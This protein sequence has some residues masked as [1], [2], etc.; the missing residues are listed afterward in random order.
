MQRTE[1]GT[2]YS[3][4]GS[5]ALAHLRILAQASLILNEAS[6]DLNC[7]FSTVARLLAEVLG[8][9][10]VVFFFADDRQSLYAG[11][12]EHRDAGGREVFG[13]QFGNGEA[14]P[15]DGS[16]TGLAVRSR[17]VVRRNFASAGQALSETHSVLHPYVEA[18]GM[19]GCLIAPL[20]SRGD[21]I[22]VIS[23]VRDQGGKPYSDEDEILLAELASRAA[24]TIENAR[25]F[26]R[27]QKSE[28]EAAAMAC[29]LRLITD[30]VPAQISY[31]DSGLIYRSVN[32]AYE[33]VWS[34]PR[35]QIIGMS[36]E[37]LIGPE[38]F[39]HV[40][41]YLNRVRAGEAVK[42]ETRFGGENARYREISF[43]PDKGDGTVRGFFALIVDI[44]ERKHL[45]LALKKGEERFRQ[46]TEAIPQIVYTADKHG[47]TEYIN[48]QWFDYTGINP[49]NYTPEIGNHSLHPDDLM[50][51]R[52][53]W[54]DA[55]RKGEPWEARARLRRHDGMYRW[56]L[57]RV[58][59]FKD[60]QGMLTGWFGTSTDIHDQKMAQAELQRL[61]D[62]QERSL[63]HMDSFLKSSP[64]AMCLINRELRYVHA[65][66]ALAVFNGM[67][68]EEMIGRTLE[69]VIPALAPVL[70]PML[71][72]VLQTGE[73]VLNFEVEYPDPLPVGRPKTCIV[74][75]YPARSPKLEGGAVIGVGAVIVDITEHKA[76]QRRLEEA[77]R[78]RD[79]FLSI[80]SH[81]LKTPLTALQL[82]IE[83]RQLALEKRL[84]EACS[85]AHIARY[86][87]VDNRQV[88]RLTRLVEDMLDVARID[89][90]KF[91]IQRE[92]FDLREMVREVTDRFS[93]SAESQGV[94][95]H[96]EL[97]E[98]LEGEWDHFR[99]EQVY[100][101]L[102]TNA[103]RYG[104]GK[105]VQVRVFRNGEHAVLSV[106]DEGIGIAPENHERVFQRFERA[107]SANEVGG[108]GLGLYISR[109]IVES[110][111]GRIRVESELGCGAAFVVTLPL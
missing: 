77:I 38:T 69:E 47:R 9:A 16:L 5:E 46:I 92:R 66:Q 111:G 3:R 21:V 4:P 79:E 34:L 68:L 32:A 78:A 101:N 108:L 18:R 51:V 31:I 104:E 62:E 27:V 72:K 28:S 29:Q 76:N 73:P 100:L 94:P 48:R 40:L 81:E 57:I 43:V 88:L 74:S 93:P 22:G 8:D 84:P 20:V 67:P 39:A 2:Y 109:Q 95:I 54:E 96:L 7:A 86:L 13:K 37:E 75:Y 53:I 19:A 64:A 33:K 56:F 36:V 35:E 102:L 97:C 89:S 44:T 6:T 103:L 106:R 23:L 99:L 60:A 25:L 52:G 83:M 30:A 61:A 49:E 58:V 45:E 59:P 14:L 1:P 10:A 63:A 71:E 80:A 65:N 85:P 50:E 26:A 91:S 15:V 107:I 12:F 70:S 110:H 11:A 41:P 55:V 24:I 105:P 17:S 90:S 87:E 42:F 98:P 82:Q